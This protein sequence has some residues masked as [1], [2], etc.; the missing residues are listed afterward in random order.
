[1]NCFLTFL[2]HNFQGLKFDIVPSKFEENLKKE[3]FA[4]P[5]DYVR[6]TAK[7]KTLDVAH[8]LYTTEVLFFF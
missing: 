7:Q 4:T 5:L 8:R 6:E 1:M 2:L 3:N